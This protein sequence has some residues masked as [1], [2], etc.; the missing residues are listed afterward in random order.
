MWVGP[1]P[2]QP[3]HAAKIG[4]R[5]S[6]VD[7]IRWVD[8]DD[9]SGGELSN[10]GSHNFGG[11]MY[12]AQLEETGPVE[13]LPPGSGARYLTFRFANGIR[14][15]HGGAGQGNIS[16]A[17][18]KG[19]AS[20]GQQ[21]PA[22]RNSPLRQYRGNSIGA[23]FINCVRT[24]RRPFQDVEYAHRVATVCLLGKICYDL[25]RPLK[26]DPA[27]EVFPEDGVANRLLDRAKREPWSI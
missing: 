7:G 16:F 22:V 13:I 5:T 12:A 21:F 2:Q 11:A 19:T 20:A 23:D 4:N 8:M 15:Y 24:R 26:W 9:F 1:A 6:R 27:K 3:F 18:D 25:K 17:G 10:W 14:M